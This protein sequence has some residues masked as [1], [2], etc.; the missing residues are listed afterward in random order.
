M[1]SNTFILSEVAAERLDTLL[2]DC[3]EVGTRS[4]AQKLIK[5]GAVKINDKVITKA[6]TKVEVTDSVE[7]NYQPEIKNLVAVAHYLDIRYE[8]AELLVVN[9]PKGMVVHPSVG[10]SDDTLANYL[11]SHCQLSDLNSE[12]PGIVH[13]I[14]KDTSGLL[15]V[16]KNNKAHE[17]LAQ[18]FAL[19][20]TKRL[21]TAICWGNPLQTRGT[22]DKPLGRHRN[23]RKKQAVIESGKHAVTHW[24]VIKRF[25]GLSLIECRLET[26][27]T[28]QIRVHMAETGH[29][30]LGDP[31][32]GRFRDHS[33]KLGQELHLEL[34]AFTG[35]ALHAGL[36]GFVHPVTKE[37][38]E[39][40][41]ELPDEITNLLIKLE[42][43]LS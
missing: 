3:P 11:L 27:R 43:H 31:L 41:A 10:H 14:D 1:K 16:A 28:H 36:L 23:H 38:M 26:G 30:L 33:K 7:V 4:Q 19:R 32:Y 24:R 37:E 15:V 40:T 5:E 25:V 12:R 35:Q 34:K 13:R 2:A 39:F 22:V 8:D 9:K 6:K 17:D 29:A 21:Y 42:D 20:Q 18:Q